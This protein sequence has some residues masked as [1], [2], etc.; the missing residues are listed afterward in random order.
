[1]PPE[2]KYYQGKYV[3]KNPA[4]YEGDPTQVIYRSSWEL[5]LFNWCD[6]SPN[7]LRWSSEEIVVPYICPSDNKP[8]RYFVDAKVVVKTKD[9]Q[10]RTFLVEV[11]PKKET[12][13]PKPPKRK[14]KRFLQEVM[15][16]GK[17]Q[18]KWEA[19]HK[20]AKQRGW[21]FKI[22][23]ETNLGLDKRAK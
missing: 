18:A 14:T 8:H 5:R 17:N 12:E 1:M 23:T 20:Y 4:K 9:N 22:I 13:P 7:V 3:P 19:A 10:T 15:T 6:T 16:W 2:G 21:D 11:K